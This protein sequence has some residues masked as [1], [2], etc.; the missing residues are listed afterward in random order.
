MITGM[1]SRAAP[2]VPAGPVSAPPRHRRRHSLP[3]GSSH[4]SVNCLAGAPCSPRCTIVTTS[5]TFAEFP[6]ASSPP[7]GQNLLRLEQRWRPE[8]AQH[9]TASSPDCRVKLRMSHL[10]LLLAGSAMRRSAS[11]L[12]RRVGCRTRLAVH[13]VE[14]GHRCSADPV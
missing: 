4:C 14:S 10:V 3:R 5:Q 9:S 2:A 7:D 8:F 13:G 1:R 6:T 11:S 12:P